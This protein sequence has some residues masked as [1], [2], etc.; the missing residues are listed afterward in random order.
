MVLVSGLEIREYVILGVLT[1]SSSESVIIMSCG[2]EQ[3]PMVV[4]SYRAH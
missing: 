3:E 4:M 1:H 2:I